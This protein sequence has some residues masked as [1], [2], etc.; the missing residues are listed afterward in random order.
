RRSRALRRSRSAPR[1]RTRSSR[2]SPRRRATRRPNGA[3]DLFEGR[4]AELLISVVLALIVLGPEKL[5]RVVTE[6]GRWMGRARAMARQFR[7]QL[8]EEVQLEQARKANSAGSAAAAGTAAAGTAALGMAAPGTADPGTADP[9]TLGTSA[10]GAA[11]GGAS[12]VTA[13][14]AGAAAAE[15]PTHPNTFSHAHATDATGAD[16]SAVRAGA[17]SSADERGT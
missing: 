3:R 2:T 8:E 15:Q 5:P 14:P 9:G 6:I 13:P 16:P 1:A 10:P 11:A 4:F 12:P 7:E 17:A